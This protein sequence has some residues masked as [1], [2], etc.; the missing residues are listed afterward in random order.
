MQEIYYEEQ[1]REDIF[2]LHTWEL[3]IGDILEYFKS[4]GYGNKKL[5]ETIRFSWQV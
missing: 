3:E 5:L 1:P 2:S 4:L